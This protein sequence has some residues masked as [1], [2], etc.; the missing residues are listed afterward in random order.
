MNITDTKFWHALRRNNAFNYFYDRTLGRLVK[1]FLLR[2]RK[3]AI[4]ESGL[5][6]IFQIEACLDSTGIDFFADMGTLLGFVRDGKPI[7][8][9][10]DIDFGVIIKENNEWDILESNLK[11]IGFHKDHQF[12]LMGDITEQTYEKNN[13]YVDFFN[14]Y[15][16]GKESYCYCYYSKKG[17]EYSKS[18]QLHVR[19][20][21]SPLLNGTK[22]ILVNDGEIRVP[23]ESEL[24]LE[25]LYGKNW[26]VPDPNWVDGSGPG[27]VEINNSFGILEKF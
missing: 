27:V 25:S 15:S 22:R 16:D 26:M 8:W 11:K 12:R 18:N 10:F 3:K 7:G 2:D 1:S 24:Y 21:V 9:D 20:I 5:T 17:Y 19:K 23:I 4:K 14:H 6:N 13:V